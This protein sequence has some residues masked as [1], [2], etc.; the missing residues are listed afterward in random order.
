MPLASTLPLGLNAAV[1]QAAA[2]GYL[3]D[4]NCG[5]SI[6]WTMRPP[7]DAAPRSRPGLS[8]AIAA[9]VVGS[10]S[11]ACTFWPAESQSASVL[12]VAVASSLPSGENAIC[13]VHDVPGRM[14]AATLP[15]DASHS[16]TALSWP[17]EANQFS[18]GC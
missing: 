5:G 1:R 14:R 11:K 3:R 6:R 10:G 18:P 7:I 16:T 12:P 2:A 4:V 15:L 17:D 13:S 9:I 8:Q